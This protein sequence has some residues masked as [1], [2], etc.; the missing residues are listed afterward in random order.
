MATSELGEPSTA[1]AGK[2]SSAERESLRLVF[3]GHVDHGKST[4]IGRLLHDAGS[5]PQGAV[6]KI[7]RVSAETGQPFELAHLLDAFEE[8]RRQGITIDTTRLRFSSAAR[9]YVIIDAPG[10]KEFLKNMISGAADAEAAFL[11]V[12]AQRGVEE[13]SRRHARMLSLLGVVQV[14]LAVN[15]MDLVGYDQDA[16][17]KVASELSEFALGLG[18]SIRLSLPLSALLG[19]NVCER[20]PQ[21][22]WW[23]GPTL[24]EALDSIPKARPGRGAL[25]IPI[26]DVYKFDA[27]RVLAGRIESGEVRVGDEIAINPGGKTTKVTALAAWLPRDEALSAG[28]GRSVALMVAD[29]F[30]NKRGE[31]VSLVSDPPLAAGKITASIFWMGKRPLEAG[32]RYKLRIAS[33]ESEAEVTSITRLLDSETLASGE[34][35]E[36]LAGVGSPQAA[37]GEEPKSVGR[38]QVAEVTLSLQ[39]PCALDLFSKCP[40]TGRFVLVDGYDVSGGGIVTAAEERPRAALGFVAGA[41]TARCEVFEE[42]YYDVRDMIVSK[43]GPKRA[44][45]YGPGDG[46]PL[47]GDSYSYPE[48]FDIVVFRDKVA[49]RIR[50]GLVADLLPLDR[51]E[52]DGHPVVNG[53]GFGVL[54]SSGEDWAR[55]RDDYASLTSDNEALL[56]GRWLDF[57]AFR[58]IPMGGNSGADSGGRSEEGAGGQRG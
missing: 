20:S 48:S 58:R 5:L 33:A 8:E 22:P 38:N 23:D 7:R 9:D 35:G 18:L 12:D 24:L 42:Y 40:A 37:P 57:N 31:V 49:V 56:A 34:A 47:L 52:F 13:Q 30:Y 3:T 4:V 26:Q 17:E 15:K 51:Y 11:V 28:P 21:M 43:T 14:G 32:R 54:V 39:R 16:F 46:V 53:R 2:A 19:E 27:R 55:A 45:L 6:D 41:L 29:E 25:R 1:G 50:N 10:H 36:D 44:P